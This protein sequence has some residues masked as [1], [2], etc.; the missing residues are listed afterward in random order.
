MKVPMY[1]KTDY[2]LKPQEP[3]SAEN[4]S[5]RKTR[6]K[7]NKKIIFIK[8]HLSWPKENSLLI[9]A[10]IFFSFS[11]NF[12]S[13]SLWYLTSIRNQSKFSPSTTEFQALS[14][15]S[16]SPQILPS[17]SVSSQ[18]LNHFSKEVFSHRCARHFTSTNNHLFGTT[19]TL[20]ETPANCL[21]NKNFNGICIFM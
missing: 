14:P 20:D 19:S 15:F 6:K 3:A 18:S 4:P 8:D 11:W 12:F 10:T 16:I 21:K 13:F 17:R 5:S 9:H 7:N 2:R 1:E